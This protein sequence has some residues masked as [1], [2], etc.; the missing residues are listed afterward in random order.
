MVS[1]RQRQEALKIMRMVNRFYG[2]PNPPPWYIRALKSARNGVAKLP[3]LNLSTLEAQSSHKDR[4]WTIVHGFYVAMGG[5]ALDIPRELPEWEQFVPNWACGTWFITLDGLIHLL[6]KDQMPSLTEEEIKS[7]S[8]AN[9]IAKAFVCAQALWFLTTCVTRLA[10]RI[11]ISLLELNTFGHAICALFIYLLWWEKPFE[12]DIPTEV[13]SQALLDMYA[14]A[15]IN[16]TGESPLVRLMKSAYRERLQAEWGVPSF[17]EYAATERDLLTSFDKSGVATFEAVP[18]KFCL[19]FRRQGGFPRDQDTVKTSTCQ[20]D[21]IGHLPSANYIPGEHIPDTDIEL[22]ST[23]KVPNTITALPSLNLTKQDINR[24]KMAKRA[25]ESI[26]TLQSSDGTRLNG[27]PFARRC[28]NTPEA[29]S[30]RATAGHFFIIGFT[31]PLALGFGAAAMVYGGLHALAWFAQFHSPIEQLLWRI[32]CVVVIGGIP[33]TIAVCRL[34]YSLVFRDKN[35]VAFLLVSVPRVSVGYLLTSAYV[36]AR[37]YLVVE[38]FIQLS[39]L[40]AGVYDMPEWSSYFPHI[41]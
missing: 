14:L 20:L 16:T 23:L 35:V 12:V 30:L 34:M 40:P 28:T 15:W 33:T 22:K 21:L 3:L 26:Q 19:L 27:I 7:K 18:D 4:P 32:S 39:H 5:L 38:C 31:D 2:R 9:G 24:W 25:A 37:L 1:R 11:P 41:G 29:L 10:Q 13:H 8:K 17:S 36:L 6:H